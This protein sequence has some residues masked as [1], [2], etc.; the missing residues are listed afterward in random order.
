MPDFDWKLYLNTPEA[1]EAMYADC[2]KAKESIDCEMWILAVD[3]IGRRFIDLFVKKSL[4]GVRVRLLLDMVGSYSFYISSLPE[5]LQ[6][7]GI[8]VRFFNP[9]SPWRIT[10]FTSNFFRMHHKLLVI[11]HQ[12]VYTGGINIRD[13]MKS[14]RDSNVRL[15]GELAEEASFIFARA[16]RI[17][18]QGKF[19][20]F[21]KP[22]IYVKNFAFRIFIS[23]L[24]TTSLLK[25]FAMP[26]SI[27]I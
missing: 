6:R 7:S 14:W 8:E 16:W 27:F 17:V 12:I 10:N 23:V 3:E 1:W 9:V 13:D 4:A 18:E 11:D 25:L 21:K 20:S 19:L 22:S 26:K 24:F 15:T 5:E 2:E